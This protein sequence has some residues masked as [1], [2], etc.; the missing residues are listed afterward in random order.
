LGVERAAVGSGEEIVQ[1]SHGDSR[2]ERMGFR[3]Q[4]THDQNVSLCSR[5]CCTQIYL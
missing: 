5:G 4:R 1:I 2:V 3:V